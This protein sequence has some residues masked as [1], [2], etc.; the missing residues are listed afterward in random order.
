VREL[1][2]ALEF[3]TVVL[4][5]AMSQRSEKA[6]QVRGLEVC[7]CMTKSDLISINP[8]SLKPRLHF[9]SH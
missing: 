2:L 7:R 9:A 4:D 8:R 6:A 3:E 5:F 1:L